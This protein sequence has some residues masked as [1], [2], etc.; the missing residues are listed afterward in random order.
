MMQ[1]IEPIQG[2][3]YIQ[4][5]RM[6]F[7]RTNGIL[8][9][10]AK[11]P[12]ILAGLI[13]I[14]IVIPI[15]SSFASTRSL[16]LTI[17]QDG[18]THVSSQIDVDP[19]DPDYELN[20]YGPDID[21]LVVTGENGLLLSAKI[22]GTDVTIDTFDSSKI[23]IEYDIHDL[24]SKEGRIWTFS[25]DSDIDYTVLMPKN[26]VIVGMT[27]LPINMETINE[28]NKIH[29]PQGISEINYVFSTPTSVDNPKENNTTQSID[30]NVFLI[31]GLIAIVAGVSVI[32]MKK[33][34]SHE[35]LPEQP[36]VIKNLESEN[37]EQKIS[38]IE[39]V[40]K[41]PDLREDDKA[42]VKFI[43]ENGGQA[44]ES[45]LRKKFLQPRTTMWRAVK[46]LERLGLVEIEKRDLQNLVK[47]KKE[48]ENEK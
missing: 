2:I 30:D 23:S 33:R 25:L 31:G 29:L 48:W 22:N 45:E 16:E 36:L 44:L 4:E 27:N 15:Q 14:S 35:K 34:K 32:F 3:A 5:E 40:D 10:M 46:R 41:V 9:T 6:L 19:L 11:I 47:L 21:N 39:S 26:T 12:L 18:T 13:M 7:V 37:I 38:V 17:Y 20:L 43:S 24:V 28:Q 8:E 1:Q 42:L